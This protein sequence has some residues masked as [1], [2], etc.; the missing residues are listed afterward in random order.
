MNTIDILKSKKGRYVKGQPK[1]NLPSIENSQKDPQEPDSK[2]YIK[3]NITS[4]NSS[5]RNS[6]DKANFNK[7]TFI[8]DPA[9]LNSTTRKALKTLA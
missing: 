8:N 2:N 5:R 9:S 1:S 4:I 6:F 3:Q 7:A